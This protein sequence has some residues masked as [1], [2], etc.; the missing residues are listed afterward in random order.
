MEHTNTHLP[1]GNQIS[2]KFSPSLKKFSLTLIAFGTLTLLLQL[3][4]PWSDLGSDL[5][6]DLG[7]DLGRDLGSEKGII[8]GHTKEK[9]KE[10]TKDHTTEHKTDESNKE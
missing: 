8:K 4:F 6:N 5:G 10:Y 9:I 3:A 1:S 7:N 2:F